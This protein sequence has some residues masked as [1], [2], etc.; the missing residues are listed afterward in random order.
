MNSAVSFD[1]V[2][3]RNN[4][5]RIME[6]RLCL[7]PIG[8]TWMHLYLNG[9]MQLYTG[10]CTFADK[11]RLEPRLQMSNRTSIALINETNAVRLAD[12]AAAVTDKHPCTH[13]V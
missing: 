5:F 1:V 12:V 4:E 7:D 13:H 6:S 10:Q 3:V 9:S 8:S 11:S 2:R